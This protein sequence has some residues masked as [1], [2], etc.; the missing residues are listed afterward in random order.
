M[1][2]NFIKY[3]IILNQIII[4]I[5]LLSVFNPF[6]CN[7]KFNEIN[8]LDDLIN[9]MAGILVIITG[10]WIVYSLKPN[11]KISKAYFDEAAN[12]IRISTMSNFFICF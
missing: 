7:L 12:K 1:K 4:V 2:N 9:I 8:C 3:L 5:L 6:N 10:Y 11:L